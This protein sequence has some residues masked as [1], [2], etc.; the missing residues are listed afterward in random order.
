VSRSWTASDGVAYAFRR[1]G[2]GP[3]VLLLHGF[4]GSAADWE[5]FR[6]AL[7]RLTSPIAVDLL[8]H[9]ASDAPDDPARHAVERQAADLADLLRAGGAAPA[10][11]AGYSFGARVALRL[12]ADHPDV[13]MS[14][15][16][17]SPSAGIAEAGER[18]TRRA[19]DETLACLLETDGMAAFVDRWQALPLFATERALPETDRAA[20]RVARLRNDPRGLAASLRGAGQGAMAPL[21][22][23]LP[24][25]AVPITIVAGALDPA[26]LPRAESVASAIPSAR[27]VVV[28]G[29]G[30]AVHREQPAR[31]ARELAGHLVRSSTFCT[32]ERCAVPDAAPV[33]APTSSPAGSR[34]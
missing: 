31:L 21:H 22:A 13:V 34:P 5:P 3:T 18:A 12:A 9:G 6:P 14:L 28:D 10:H 7:E 20:I 24:A 17:E 25:I 16:L 8:G 2:D 32:S 23:A 33:L 15:F 27:L 30:H 29:A 4:T 26:G 11:V 19:A 1:S